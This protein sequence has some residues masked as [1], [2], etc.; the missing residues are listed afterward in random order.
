MRATALIHNCASNLASGR[1]PL[2]K[3]DAE[4]QEGNFSFYDSMPHLAV[5]FPIF[6]GL[7]NIIAHP[8]IDVRS[9]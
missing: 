7:S 4:G 8:H 1:P 2:P 6:T 5:W 3:T 9:R